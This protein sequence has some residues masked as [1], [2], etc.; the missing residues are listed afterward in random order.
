[1]I[2]FN[3]N[4]ITLAVST[5]VLSLTLLA[6]S[7]FFSAQKAEAQIPVT[8]AA[9]LSQAIQDG[10]ARVM[11]SEI[12]QQIEQT[13][14]DM[15]ALFS[16]LE[17]DNVNNA[18]SNM[19]A[20]TGKAMQDIQ[21]IEQLEKGMPAQDICDTLTLSK[22]LDDALCDMDSKVAE[23]NQKRAAR[24]AMMTGQGTVRC[25]GDV[26][27][28]VPGAPSNLDINKQNAAAAK[29]FVTKCDALKSATGTD[30]CNQAS[31]VV[32][33]PPQGTNAQEYEAIEK[34]NEVAAGVMIQ[35]PRTNDSVESARGTPI[36]DQLRALD[37]RDAYF[38]NSFQSSLDLNTLLKEGTKDA[39]GQRKTGE[40]I[41][42][43][44]YLSTRL[45]SQNWLCEVTNTCKAP[46]MAQ[47]ANPTPY[48]SPDELE[49]RKAEMDAVLL[50]IGMQQ[51]KSMLRIERTL[52]DIGLMSVNPTGK[53][54]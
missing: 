15:M 54:K 33:P 43:D 37:T 17:I 48:V 44:I 50:F 11:E 21:N 34:M 26:C 3:K 35:P 20:R 25:T 39:S 38:R 52:A 28:G 46:L 24:V 36:H 42:L 8:D 22:N 7:S 31:L 19:I 18:F 23:Y 16:E 5:A 32:N 45:G 27:V 49:K 4:K 47:G 12:M 2:F 41:N 13:G 40:I 53:S 9:S 51:Y 10:I 14:L 30:L 6:S 1:M 29:E